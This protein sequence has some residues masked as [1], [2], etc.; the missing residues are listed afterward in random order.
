M[1]VV[2]LGGVL[3]ERIAY[4]PLR[5]AG[6]LPPIIS[7]LGAAFILE[8]VARNIYGATYILPAGVTDRPG[9]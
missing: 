3:L 7:A 6:R 4:R 8:S 2:A 9:T 1:F 5:H